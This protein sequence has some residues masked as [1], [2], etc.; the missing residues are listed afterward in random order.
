M[1]AKL[2]SLMRVVQS[3][4]TDSFTASTLPEGIVLPL[5]SAS[6]LA[7]FEDLCKTDATAK[8]AVVCITAYLL[9]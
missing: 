5:K 6:E 1:N 8:S 4:V 7:E 3:M 2:D 9:L